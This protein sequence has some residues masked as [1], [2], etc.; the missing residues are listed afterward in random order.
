[1]RTLVTPTRFL[2]TALI[3]CATLFTLA[4]FDQE[5]PTAKD[6]IGKWEGKDESDKMG[7]IEFIDSVHV[8]FI[9]DGETSPRLTYKVD[10]SKSPGWFDITMNTTEGQQTM[11]CLLEFVNKDKIKWT[12]AFGDTRPSNDGKGKDVITIVLDR[13]PAK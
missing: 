12:T 3:A 2:V 5:K 7:S 13:K 10:F 1:M 8:V 6:L 9:V 11:K 4:S